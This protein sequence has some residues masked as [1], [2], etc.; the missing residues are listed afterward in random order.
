[1]RIYKLRQSYPQ[2]RKYRL[3]LGTWRTDNC[4]RRAKRGVEEEMFV[5]VRNDG[6]V[7]S[8]DVNNGV[9]RF[10]ARHLSSHLKR[11]SSSPLQRNDVLSGYAQ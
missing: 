10:C 6:E 2:R 8:S 3:I 4:P 7:G 1:M 5:Y 9:R 11:V